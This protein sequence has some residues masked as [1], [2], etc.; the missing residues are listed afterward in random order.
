MAL[1][2]V[3]LVGG[4]IGPGAAFN[5]EPRIAIVKTGPKGSYFGYSVAQHQVRSNQPTNQQSVFGLK[6]VGAPSVSRGNVSVRR[7]KWNWGGGDGSTIHH[8]RPLYP[9]PLPYSVFKATKSN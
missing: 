1:L 5:L 2:L 7:D 6:V 8:L 4:A 3:A 9:R